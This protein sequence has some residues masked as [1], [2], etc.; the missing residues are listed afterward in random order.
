MCARQ[1]DDRCFEA[2]CS[3]DSPDEA[4]TAIVTSRGNRNLGVRWRRRISRSF[5]YS[6]LEGGWGGAS[7]RH[8]FS[9]TSN[10]DFGVWFNLVGLLKLLQ[11]I[12][13]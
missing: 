1:T 2:T 10:A 6:S 11:S 9:L 5:Y 12:A 4:L 7:F 8:F 13:K 3:L